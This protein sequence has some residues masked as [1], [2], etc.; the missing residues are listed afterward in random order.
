MKYTYGQVFGQGC[1]S[2]GVTAVFTVSSFPNSKEIG[3]P[4]TIITRG[5]IFTTW[6]QV[7]CRQQTTTSWSRGPMDITEVKLLKRNLACCCLRGGAP[8]PSCSIVTVSSL[9][10]L[11][12]IVIYCPP[13]PLGDFLE[14]IDTQLNL[15]STASMSHVLS[16]DIKLQ[17]FLLSANQ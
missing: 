4:S 15:F 13:D 11:L 12:V 10:S 16:G 17:A 2:L 7:L 1:N 3:Q 9:I 14:E 6:M 5:I 8:Y